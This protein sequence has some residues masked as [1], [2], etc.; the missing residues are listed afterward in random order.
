MQIRPRVGAALDIEREL[1]LAIKRENIA[2][3]PPYP[4]QRDC[5]RPTTTEQI[6]RPF[7]LAEL[8]HQ[9]LALLCDP[10]DAFR[11]RRQEE[12][13]PNWLLDLRKVRPVSQRP[14][15]SHKTNLCDYIVPF[16]PCH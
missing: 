5:A 15:N 1:R 16:R 12:F 2:E 11:L 7:S 6:L 13:T 14:S 4:E 10:G 9:V 3:L 8:Q